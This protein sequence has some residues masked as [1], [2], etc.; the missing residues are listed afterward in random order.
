MGGP[1]ARDPGRLET[2]LQDRAAKHFTVVQLAVAPWWAGAKDRQGQPAFL[3]EHLERW[4]PVFWKEYERKINAAND[5]G[6]FVLIVGIMEPTTRYPEAPEAIR[7]AHQIAARFYGHFVAFSP[8]FDSGYRELGDAAGAA[9]REATSVHLITQHPGTPSGQPVNTIAE[10]YFDRP[11]LDFA[12]DQSG[13]N[14]GNLERCSR[15]AIEWNLH[16]F[17]RRPPK[18][19]INLEAMYDTDSPDTTRPNAWRGEDARRLAY[20]S[21]LSGA[22][23]YTYGSDLYEWVS[24]ASKPG[25]WAGIIKLPSSTEMKRLHDLLAQFPWWQLHP[26]HS[27]VLDLPKSF[28]KRPVFARTESFDTAL[29]YLP[30]QEPIALNLE[31]FPEKLR[32]R[33]YNPRTGEYLGH[34]EEPAPSSR[35]HF[36]PPGSGDWVLVLESKQK[37]P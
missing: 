20:Q 8:S 25:Y 9:L 7:F 23:G 30:T 17:E 21:W 16:L 4:N 15:Q 14:G 1:N 2:Y 36:T 6:I 29:A 12:G 5:V 37:E 26:D 18:P 24:D 3:G 13:H 27:R 31:G 11:Y 19:V 33:W 22:M 32:A 10:T 28:L 35:V 34:S